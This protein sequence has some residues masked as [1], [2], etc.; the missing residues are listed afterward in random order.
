MSR[1]AIIAGRGGLPAA[2]VAALP[3]RPLVAALEGFAPDGLVPDQTF[4]VERLALFLRLLT[5]SG[6]SRVVFAG[7]VQ[8]P[9]LDPAL[10]DPQTAQM[11]PRLLAAMQAGDDATLRE[12][13]AIFEEAGFAVAGVQD[14]APDLVPGPGTLCGA[15]SEADSRDAARA[16][17]IVAALGGVDVGQGAVVAQ[18]LCLAVEALPGTDAMLDWVAQTA[19]QMGARPNPAGAKGV[20]YKAPKPGQD[21]RIDLPTLGLET[22]RRAARAGLAGIAWQAGGVIVLDRAAMIAEAERLGLFLWAR[23]A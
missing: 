13:V 9:W 4:R 15:P 14:I 7:A 12:V 19:G 8:R 2:L 20:F 5:D 21:H 11:V 10:F 16:A 18:G 3:E 22:L 23:E 6:V 1:T 17:V